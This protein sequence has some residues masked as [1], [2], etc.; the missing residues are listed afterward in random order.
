M[1]NLASRFGLPST[2][3]ADSPQS[4]RASRHVRAFAA[5]PAVRATQAA[6]RRRR[7]HLA[8]PVRFLFVAALVPLSF[9]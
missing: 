8:Y 7:F 1:S 9:V 5:G 4:P 3:F 6:L 2:A